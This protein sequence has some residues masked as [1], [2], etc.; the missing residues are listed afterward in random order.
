MFKCQCHREVREDEHRKD[1]TALVIKVSLVIS[2]IVVLARR[3]KMGSP[4]S[5]SNRGLGIKSTFKNELYFR[6]HKQS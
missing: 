1:P 5:E 4:E 6:T 2:D 3:V